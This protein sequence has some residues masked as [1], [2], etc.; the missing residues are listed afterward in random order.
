MVY[1]NDN[2]N[3]ISNLYKEIEKIIKTIVIKYSSKAEDGETLESKQHADGYIAAK[4]ERDTFMSYSDYLKDDYEAV[5]IFDENIISKALTGDTS[6]VPNQFRDALL[7]IRR[8]R[9]ISNFE[10]QNDYYRILSG[11]P[12]KSTP[13]EKYHYVP[14]QIATSLGINKNIP[15]HKIQDYYNDTVK[16]GLGDYYIQQIESFGIIRNLKTNFP[17]EEYLN[18]IGKNRISIISAREAKNFQILKLDRTPIRTIVYDQFVRIYE[19]CRSYFMSTIYVRDYRGFFDYYDNF[20]GLCIMVMTIQQMVMRQISL[21]IEREFFDIYAVQMLYEAYNVPYDLKIDEET[22]RQL[23]QSLNCLIN[24]KSTNKV[25]YDIAHILGFSNIEVYKYYLA[26]ERKYDIY[27]VPVVGTKEQFNVDTGEVETLPDYDKMYDVHFQ[28]CDLS[29]D[30]FVTTF[31][32]ES[33]RV[34]YEDIV[35]N[36]AYWWEDQNLKNRVWDTA[37]NFVETKYL[38]LGI[39]YRLTDLVYENILLLKFLIKK[40]PEIESVSIYLPKILLDESVPLF[41]A[42]ILLICL[43]A[44]QHHLRGEIVSIPTQVISVLDYFH[45]VD[46]EDPVDT[47]SFN[48]DYFTTQEGKD[49][50]HEVFM[51]LGKEDGAEFLKYISILSIDSQSS[52]AEKI[53][54][55]NA[56][57]DNIKNLSEF[58]S[59]HMART[60]SRRTYEAL[61]TFYNAAFY[62]KE[63][64]SVFTIVGEKTGYVRTAKTFF[65]YLYYKNQKLYEAVFKVD[66]EAQYDQYLQ[67]HNLTSKKFPISEFYRLAETGEID[68]M[69][70]DIS[71]V[72]LDDVVYDKEDDLIYY[73]VNHIISQMSNIIRG[74]N[75]LY[76]SNGTATPL[77]NLMVKLVRFFKSHTV[78]MIG[79]DT[80]IICDMRN[81]NL[82]RFFDEVNYI[83]KT[84][85]PK[86]DMNISYSDVINRIKSEMD[87]SDTLKMSDKEFHNK[88]LIIDK[89]VEPGLQMTD[90]I[91]KMWY[92]DDDDT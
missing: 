44:K 24:E 53:Q 32:N 91:H 18:Y 49:Q 5:G 81:D 90:K 70:D 22:Q 19:Q 78:D 57:F 48:F 52:N 13:E 61:K 9:E 11:Y 42:I 88:D 66:K 59:Y 51:E 35:P 72:A 83:E 50:V 67:D 85:V 73:Y 6:V 65:E 55:I 80:I 30:D 12:P 45:N 64:K 43:T 79:L 20:I 84:I 60:K 16:S 33:N 27:G 29:N 17:D 92:S 41:D 75:M 46:G 69:Y 2:L 26:R 4:E 7:K 25:I 39:S 8:Q 56:I 77:E 74:L 68:I 58:L 76:F 38:G 89:K 54:A 15:I 34:E 63:V 47:F 82:L 62:A 37:Y 31:N 40:S 28:K 23:L 1:D 86:D 87:L 21:S 71:N 10:E 14:E 3:P 36:D